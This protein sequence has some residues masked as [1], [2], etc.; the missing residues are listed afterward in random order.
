MKSKQDTALDCRAASNYLSRYQDNELDLETRRRVSAHLHRCAACGRE[1]ALLEQVT[2]RVKH[3]PGLDAPLNFTAAVMGK[4]KE[5]E[6]S[7]AFKWPG[8]P[9]PL[10]S[11]AYSLVFIVFLLLG[12]WFAAGPAG[13]TLSPGILDDLPDQPDAYIARTLEESRDLSLLSVQDST[14]ELLIQASENGGNHEE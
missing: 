12:L 1:L 8:L 11:M 10:A 9:A 13:Q 4:I 2:A 14:L 7:R 6:E 3:L 5:K